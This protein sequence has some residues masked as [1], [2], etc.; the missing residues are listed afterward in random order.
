MQ[1]IF[2]HSYSWVLPLCARSAPAKEPPCGSI[3]TRKPRCQGGI[4]SH[5]IAHMAEVDP[6]DVE[7]PPPEVNPTGTPGLTYMEVDV[8]TMDR[9]R[10]QVE[11]FFGYYTP[12][13]LPV[14]GSLPARAEARV[15][16]QFFRGG[17]PCRSLCRR[18]GRALCFGAVA[19]GGECFRLCPGTETGPVHQL[20]ALDSRDNGAQNHMC[21]GRG[22]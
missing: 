14:D 20:Y 6:A 3:W 7:K 9:Y 2:A 13:S 16:L 8:A 5:A 11:S 1:S 21:C 12:V 22:V 17:F 4:S 10:T 15:P 18:R 19:G